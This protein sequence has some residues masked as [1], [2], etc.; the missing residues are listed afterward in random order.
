MFRAALFEQ[1]GEQR[2]EVAVT[3]DICGK[4]ESF[5][6]RLD[7]EAQD[8]IKKA[9]LHRK[10]ATVVFFESNGG[11]AKEG[12]ATVPEIRLAVAEPD[13]DV[14][15]VETAVEALS[16]SCYYLRVERNKFRFGLAPNL[17]KLLADRRANVD[18]AKIEERIRAEILKTFEKQPGVEVVPFPEK[19]G[20]IPDRPILA[21]A[22]LPPEASMGE[23]KTLGMIDTMIRECG[24][25]GRTFKS[26]LLFAVADDDAALR[27]EARKLLAWQAIKDDEEDKLDISQQSQLAENLRKAQR[28][29]KECVWRTY[30]NV[31]LLGKDNKVRWVDLGL[32]HSSQAS[33]MVKLIVDRLRQDSDIETGVSPTFLVRNWPPA[34]TEWSTKSMRDAFFASPQFPRLIDGDSVKETIARGVSNGIIAYVGKSGIEYKP[35]FFGSEIGPADVEISDDMFIITADE[36]KKHIEPPKLSSLSIAP[37]RPPVKPGAHITFQAKGNDQHGRPMEPRAV[38][39]KMKGGTGDASG[40][41]TA[42]DA[43]GEFLIEASVGAVSRERWC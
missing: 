18:T 30:K 35:F 20:Q 29:L 23:K 5:A 39:W 32:V 28:D 38:T 3:T 27:D 17:N 16:E 42:A 4:K 34:F 41:F 40:G 9:R 10:V 11:Q 33:G 8:T 6:T 25:S 1:L 15:N 26:A 43:E 19:T 22:V 24:N 37:E 31:A 2:L 12:E 13:L 14:G 36:A 7:A 21:L